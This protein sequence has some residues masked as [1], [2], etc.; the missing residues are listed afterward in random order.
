MFFRGGSSSYSNS[1]GDLSGLDKSF[2]NTMKVN[3]DGTIGSTFLI[4]TIEF[5]K[6]DNFCV[7]KGW[8]SKITVGNQLSFNSFPVGKIDS[9]ISQNDFSFKVA[10]FESHL[11]RKSRSSL[12]VI[13]ESATSKQGMQGSNKSKKPTIRNSLKKQARCKTLTKSMTTDGEKNSSEVGNYT[14]AS[15]KK[16]NC[17]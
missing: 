9:E 5:A 6:G 17:T 3:G 4:S 15:K 14:S 1:R 7:E 11:K 13:I 8:D 2:L 16:R 12:R 10:Y